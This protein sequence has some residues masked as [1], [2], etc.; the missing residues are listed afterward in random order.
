MAHG[1]PWPIAVAFGKIQGLLVLSGA[2]MPDGARD[3]RPSTHLGH[4]GL[5]CR[6]LGS[7]GFRDLCS[8]V[9]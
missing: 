5:R 4:G 6:G 7:L 3:V 1:H 8:L 2:F 9:V